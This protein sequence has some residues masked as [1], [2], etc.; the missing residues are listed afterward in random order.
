MIITTKASLYPCTSSMKNN[1]CITSLPQCKGG[2]RRG[3]PQSKIINLKL[4]NP[5]PDIPFRGAKLHADFYQLTPVRLVR[6]QVFLV[7]NLL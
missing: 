7:V 4:I 3:C 6:E 2:S 5:L 1:S